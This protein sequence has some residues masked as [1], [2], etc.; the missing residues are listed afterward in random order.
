MATGLWVGNIPKELEGIVGVEGLDA[1][2]DD[3]FWM[4]AASQYQLRDSRQG[5]AIRRELLD[6]CITA[7]RAAASC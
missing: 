4:L 7:L 3:T 6:C 5:L 2:V 1:L